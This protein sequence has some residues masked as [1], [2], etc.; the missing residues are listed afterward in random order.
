MLQIIYM[1]LK[2]LSGKINLMIA[3]SISRYQSLEAYVYVNALP[4]IITFLAVPWF[5][6]I[7]GIF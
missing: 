6:I 5:I 3:I 4:F 7:A 1:I 2:K